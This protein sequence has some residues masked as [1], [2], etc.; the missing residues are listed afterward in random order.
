MASTFALASGVALYGGFAG[1]E[2]ALEQRDIAANSTVLSGDIDQN[3][4]LL[5]NAYHV[6][7]G[8]GTDDTAVLDGFT[9]TAGSSPDDGGGIYIVSGSPTLTNATISGNAADNGGGIYLSSSSPII[10]RSTVSGNIAEDGGGIYNDEGS[11]PVITSTSI[12]SNTADFSGGGIYN[13]RGSAPTI[14][15]S[16]VSGNTAATWA[17]GSTTMRAIRSSPARPSPRM[18]PVTSRARYTTLTVAR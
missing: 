1:W 11:N 4:T 13:R 6:V 5:N 8:S 12:S 15:A 16:T 9:V 10:T 7:T 2:T 14:T 17:R 3:G 18:M